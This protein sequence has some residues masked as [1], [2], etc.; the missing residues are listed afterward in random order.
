MVWFGV[1]GFTFLGALVIAVTIWFGCLL[2][3]LLF[4]LLGWLI[5]MV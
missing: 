5:L 3:G 4:N 2:V 1:R